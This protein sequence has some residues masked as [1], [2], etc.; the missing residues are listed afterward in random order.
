M[1]RRRAGVCL[2]Q[3]FLVNVVRNRRAGRAAISAAFDHDHD[4]VTRIFIGRKRGKPGGAVNLLVVLVH[5]LRRAGLAANV[6]PGHRGRAA[7][8][9]RVLGFREHRVAQNFQIARMH[10]Q[11]ICAPRPT[12]KSSALRRRP[13]PAVRCARPAAARAPCRRWRWP[14]TP[15]PSAS[16]SRPF[17]PGRNK[18]SPNRRR[19]SPD[20]APGPSVG[21]MPVVSCRV[22]RPVRSPK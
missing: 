12:G 7:G 19:A 14:N 17:R 4:G 18:C 16:A 2:F 21:K 20:F 1:V 9:F 10:V 5:H 8:A 3:N 22:G 11:I 6:Q 13:G 15:R